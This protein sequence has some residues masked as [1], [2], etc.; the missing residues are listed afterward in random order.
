[1]AY[2]VNIP[3]IINKNLSDEDREEIISFIN[4]LLNQTKKEVKDD[5]ITIVEEKFERRL[6]EEISK[7]RLE[8]SE[9]IAN[10]K[11]ETIKWIFIFWLGNVITIIG[12]IIGILKIARV[13]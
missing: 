2:V 9:K 3:K 12:G 6:T 4:E 1:M 7:V 10:S 13:L 8:L 11:A 5:I